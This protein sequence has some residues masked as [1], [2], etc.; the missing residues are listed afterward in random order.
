MPVPVG[1]HP[2]SPRAN[3]RTRTT[4][5]HDAHR[6]TLRPR[7]VSL[8][9][10]TLNM[11]IPPTRTGLPYAWEAMEPRRW[12]DE[13]NS[14]RVYFTEPTQHRTRQ[15]NRVTYINDEQR[16]KVL[17]VWSDPHDCRLHSDQWI[18]VQFA[19]HTLYSGEWAT[20]MRMLMAQGCTIRG[21]SRVDIAC[22][23]I[24]GEGG[25]WPTVIEA[26][27]NGNAKYYGKC[28]WM[29]R[30]ARGRVVGG[31]FGTR[32]SNKF[33]R[34]YRKKREMKSKGVKEHI[35]KAWESAFGFDPMQRDGVEVNRFEVQLKGKEIRRY[36]PDE[37]GPRAADFVLSLADQVNRVDVFA[38]MAAGMFDF[39]HRAARACDA[40][41][42]AV[43]DWSA[44]ARHDPAISFRASRNLAVTDHTIKT[45]LRALFQLAVVTADPNVMELAER[46]AIAAGP[47]YVDWFGRKKLWWTKEY[48]KLIRAG[49]TR[50][51]E[52]FQRL[53]DPPPGPE[54]LTSDEWEH[55]EQFAEMNKANREKDDRPSAFDPDPDGVAPW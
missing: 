16:Q 51:A 32:G 43:W 14:E 17:T 15:F 28:D 35:V 2:R 27:R 50:T 5:Q 36:F 8:D 1:V 49:D 42:L 54:L 30:S 52:F 37:K 25:D 3:A 4:G 29:V 24:E 21:I 45:G 26:T 6:I 19:N 20:L 41:P 33:I 44:V 39:R 34:A 10:L 23:A 13:S 9:W 12:W 11:D 7:L 22:D 46:Q 38:S 47:A 18:Q 40:R 53:A 48:Q 31:E 55:R